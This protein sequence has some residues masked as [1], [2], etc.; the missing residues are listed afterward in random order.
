MTQNV[1]ATP[2]HARTTQKMT[3]AIFSPITPSQPSSSSSARTPEFPRTGLPTPQHQSTHHRQR[4]LEKAP[5]QRLTRSLH[6]WGGLNGMPAILDHPESL[7]QYHQA[8]T[9]VLPW[10]PPR[11]L[12]QQANQWTALRRE[13]W[14]ELQ[15]LK[16]PIQGC[17]LRRTW[18]LFEIASDY[19]LF[20]MY[21]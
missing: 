8:I 20:F 19:L 9:K 4:A 17:Y 6:S 1:N 12:G 21:L 5:V 15:F 11:Q 10:L 2:C 13:K 18:Y 3:H 7:H 14:S 16:E